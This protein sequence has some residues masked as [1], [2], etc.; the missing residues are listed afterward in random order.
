M[1]W[2][3]EEARVSGGD[4]LTSEPDLRTHFTENPVAN[5]FILVLFKRLH[6]HR[7]REHALLQIW[8]GP[9]T[10]H[11]RLQLLLLCQ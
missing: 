10:A 11:A 3:G 7:R 6:L 2:T 5:H 8:S 9:V 1:V 4:F